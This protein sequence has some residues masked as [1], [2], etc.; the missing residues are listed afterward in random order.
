MNP[1]AR[2]GLFLAIL[3]GI[4]FIASGWFMAVR[5]GDYYKSE[6]PPKH[7]FK[8][9]TLRDLTAFGR[10]VS[11]T[12]A[13]DESGHHA[14]RVRYGEVE[15][16]V[17][18]HAPPVSG[19]PLL[20]AYDEWLSLLAFAP[21]TDGRADVGPD[22]P[23]ARLILVWRIAAPGMDDPM[24]ALK[25]RNRWTFGLIEFQRD[26]TLAERLLQFPDKRGTGKLK[27][28]SDSV[29]ARVEP[30]AQ[31]SWEWQA[32]LFVIP[33][34]HISNYRFNTDATT[35]MGWTLPVAGFSMLGALVGTMMFAVGIVPR[36]TAVSA[37]AGK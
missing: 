30:I 29:S 9:I 14:L 7:L 15:R 28:I 31:R 34:L 26:G 3:S 6:P 17:P 20:D 25:D 16:L 35:A 22:A 33:R 23:D 4:T 36:A 8:R 24:G 2:A 21:M 5:I 32:A 10:P 13:A 11:L 1:T 19:R 18:V 27:F 12:D 37:P